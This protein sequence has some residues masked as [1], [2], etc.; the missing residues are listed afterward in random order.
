M[1]RFPS[2]GPA[3]CGPPALR[4]ATALGRIGL[5]NMVDSGGR[6]I[7]RSVAAF[8]EFPVSLSPMLR[9]DAIFPIRLA[10]RRDF[11]LSS[12][13]SLTVLGPRTP[14]DANPRAAQR[15]PQMKKIAL[16]REYDLVP[17]P[18]SW[19]ALLQCFDRT[20]TEG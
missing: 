5:A 4:T 8:L 1:R 10:H 2:F 16:P 13:P 11:Q 20:I 18:R 9:T 19:L 12:S 17:G 7:S 6:I 3:L 14:H 15:L